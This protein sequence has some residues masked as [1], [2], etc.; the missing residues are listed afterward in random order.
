MNIQELFKL[1]MKRDIN[2][3]IE[4][5][6]SNAI[7]LGAGNSPMPGVT[8][9]DYPEWDASRDRLPY[10]DSSVTAVF[11]FH[12]M[13]HLTGAEAI[14]MLRE[15]QRVLA[16]GGTANILVPYYKSS[17]AFQDLDHKSFWNEE[18]Y[19]VLFRNPYYEKNREQPWNLDV[20]VNL[21]IGVV[22]RNLALM[23]QLVKKA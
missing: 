17:M 22:E 3:L 8:S 19:R 16:P 23:T 11:A 13:E 15:I 10:H 21:V 20:H 1:G 14:N 9:L 18:S 12:F 4:P 6:L 7:N 5:D 2:E